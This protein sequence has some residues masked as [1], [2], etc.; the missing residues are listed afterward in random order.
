MYD[1][2]RNLNTGSEALKVWKQDFEEVL[3][4]GQSPGVCEEAKS[5]SLGEEFTKEEIRQTLL[6]LKAKAAAVGTV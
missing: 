2:D 4:G 6:S 3:N 5:G 1:K